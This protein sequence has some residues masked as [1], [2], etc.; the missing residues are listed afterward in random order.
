MVSTTVTDVLRGTLDNSNPMCKLR[1]NALVLSKI[2]NE[3]DKY[4]E[5]HIDRDSVAWDTLCMLMGPFP[6]PT[7]LCIN[8]MP[9]DL[10][11]LSFRNGLPEVCRPYLSLIR[12]CRTSWYDHHT[13]DENRDR[14]A[15]LTISE[16]YVDVGKPHRRQGLH[17]ERPGALRYGGRI[18]KA[19]NEQSLYHKLAWGLGH[20]GFSEKNGGDIPI[21]GIYMA[22]NVSDSCQIYPQLIVEP[23]EVTDAHG[24]IEHMRDR[25]GTGRGL[26]ANELVWFTDRTPHESLPIPPQPDGG[27]RVHRQF[28]RLVVGP[29]SVWY[30]K[31]NTPNPDGLLPDAPVSDEDKFSEGECAS[32]P[33]T[34]M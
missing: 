20:Y 19:C 11:S 14:V 13:G 8:M 18:V 4:Y 1:G 32:V 3:V 12:A 22:S 10:K 30:S 34:S 23:H 26:A 6:K 28:F 33:V 15:Y 31:H 9:I 25:L 17:I 29:I 27:T 5:D 2:L 24:G 7:G 21:D 16:S